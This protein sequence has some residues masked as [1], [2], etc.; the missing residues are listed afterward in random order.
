V[1]GFTIGGNNLLATFS[2]HDALLDS[3]NSL[4]NLDSP[5]V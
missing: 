4:D 1:T 3:L 5:P 2:R